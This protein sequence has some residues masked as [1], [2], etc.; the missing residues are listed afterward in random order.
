MSLHCSWLLRQSCWKPYL[1]AVT[2][3]SVRHFV[4][5]SQREFSSNGKLVDVAVNENTGISTVTMQRLPVNSLNLELLQEL[6]SVLDTLEK[7]RS[8]GMILTSASPTVF[9]AGLDILE[10]YKP[11]QDRAVAFWTTLQDVWLKLFGSSYPTV[12]AINGHSPAGGCLVALSCEYR[13]MVGPKYTIG[14]NETQLGIVAPKWFQFSM[15]NVI[16][17]RQAELALTTGRLF[18]TDEALKI[19]LIDEVAT[20][21]ADAIAKAEK[22]LVGMSKISATARKLAKLSC[23]QEPLEWLVAN[24]KKDLQE[25]I[26]FI[27]QPAVQMGLDHYLESLKKK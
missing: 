27:N 2:F 20:D 3:N 6:Y 21:K 11:K 1:S 16:S 25:F 19:G 10:M 24:K 22:F 4:A 5:R 18:T 13:V 15:K 14:L 8:R 23:R 7:D 17:S 12:A 9:S 26:G